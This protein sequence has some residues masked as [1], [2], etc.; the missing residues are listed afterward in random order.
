MI[1]VRWVVIVCVVWCA[2][3]E[4][5]DAPPSALPTGEPLVTDACAPTALAGNATN[6]FWIAT[7]SAGPFLAIDQSYL[8]WVGELSSVHRQEKAQQPTSYSSMRET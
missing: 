7:G 5:V 1:G 6:V 2:A 8:Y 4:A 3:P